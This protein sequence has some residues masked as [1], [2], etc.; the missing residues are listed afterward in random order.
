M[1]VTTYNLISF[2]M[3]GFV[4]GRTEYAPVQYDACR[5]AQ[6]RRQIWGYWSLGSVARSAAVCLTQPPGCVTSD[7]CPNLRASHMPRFSHF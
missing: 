2:D 6:E 3:H 4:R 7:A 5:Q 1:F